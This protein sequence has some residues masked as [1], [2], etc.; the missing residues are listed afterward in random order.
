VRYCALLHGNSY[1]EQPRF[2]RL[3]I[4]GFSPEDGRP[5]GGGVGASLMNHPPPD[6]IRLRRKVTGMLSHER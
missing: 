1:D 6:D 3:A 5:R 4:P 2:E